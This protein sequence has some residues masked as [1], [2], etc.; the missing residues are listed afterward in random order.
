MDFNL[1]TYAVNNV[2]NLVSSGWVK[3][4]AHKLI[5]CVATASVSENKEK[6]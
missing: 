5:C 6:Y 4:V 1:Y 2:G 3:Y